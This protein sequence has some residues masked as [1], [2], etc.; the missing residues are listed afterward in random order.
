ME[1]F[2]YESNACWGMVNDLDDL[3]E[4]LSLQIDPNYGGLDTVDE[5]LDKSKQCADGSMNFGTRL[6]HTGDKSLRDFLTENNLL[7]EFLS[8]TNK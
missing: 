8:K 7:D 2:W 4:K 1:K 5:F 3:F 6:E